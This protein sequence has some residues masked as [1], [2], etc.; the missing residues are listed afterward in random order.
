MLWRMSCA[1]SAVENVES[2]KCCAVSRAVNVV[3][4][5]QS[6]QCREMCPERSMLW[7]VSRAVNVV[8][9]VQSGQCCGMCPERSMSW[10][11]SRAVNVV[12]RV[13]SGQCGVFQM[14]LILKRMTCAISAVENVVCDKCCG[15]CRVR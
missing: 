8:G 13:Q 7:D 5:V 11:V 9:C 15:E 4:C 2:D 10:D 6:G 14:R 3:G 12:G 1:D